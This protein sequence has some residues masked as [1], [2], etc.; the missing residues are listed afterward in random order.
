M[1]ATYLCAIGGIEQTHLRYDFFDAEGWLYRFRTHNQFAI[2]ASKAAQ[3]AACYILNMSQRQSAE[4]D[5]E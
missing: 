5:I 1:G 3:A 4:D 2:V